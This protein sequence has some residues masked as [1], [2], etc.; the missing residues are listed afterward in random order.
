MRNPHH[1]LWKI[2]DK[3]GFSSDG[4]D[5]AESASNTNF[6]PIRS[7]KQTEVYRFMRGST[8]YYY[9]TYTTPSFTQMIKDR[10]RGLWSDR[11]HRIHLELE[12]AGIMAP[13]IVCTALLGRYGVSISEEV[14]GQTLKSE[15]RSIQ[16]NGRSDLM[17]SLGDSVGCLHRNG[18]SHGDLRWGNM[19]VRITDGQREFVYLDNERTRLFGKLPL[20]YRKKNLVQIRLSGILNEMPES[21]W[22]S[23]YASYCS[24][25]CISKSCAAKWEKSIK[26]KAMQRFSSRGSKSR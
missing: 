22:D 4:I 5:F 25:G 20:Y 11:V 26:K 1:P 2:I 24:S 16:A 7:A 9:K 8:W 3:N 19:I 17:K 15:Y 21:E 6:E 23:F 12:R 14:Q 18:F 13:T 10:F